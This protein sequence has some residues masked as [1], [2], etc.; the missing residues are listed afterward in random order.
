MTSEF[1]LLRIQITKYFWMGAITTE[2][3]VRR[4]VPRHEIVVQQCGNPDL[5]YKMKRPHAAT[6]QE[7]QVEGSRSASCSSSRFG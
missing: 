2:D 7:L 5:K 6:I 3:V 4:D 1:M